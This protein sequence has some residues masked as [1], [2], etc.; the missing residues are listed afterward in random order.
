LSSVAPLPV[1]F[2]LNQNPVSLQ[3]L[4]APALVQTQVQVHLVGSTDWRTKTPFDWTTKTPF[5][6]TTK[7]PCCLTGKRDGRRD[8]WRAKIDPKIC[9][10][11]VTNVTETTRFKIKT[12]S[13]SDLIL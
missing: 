2:P 6:W 13:D 11:A 1:Q 12:G 4:L 8:P 7:M 5:D 3:S 10:Q 9:W